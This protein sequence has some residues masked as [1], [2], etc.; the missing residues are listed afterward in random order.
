MAKKRIV[1]VDILRG[2]AAILMILGHSF[3]Q[4]PVNIEQIPWCFYLRHFIYTFHM[5]LF[6]VLAGVV[7]HCTDYK[8]FIQKKIKRILIPYAFFGVVTLL[9]KAFGGSAINGNETVKEGLIKFVFHGGNYWFLYVLF[10]V[11]AIYPFLEKLCQNRI[12]YEIAFGIGILIIREITNV[13]W[14]LNISGV[15]H[16][17]PFFILGRAV[18]KLFIAKQIKDDMSS[19][20][21]IIIVLSSC[22]LYLAIDSF[23]LI[24][25]T[26]VGM[27]LSF[28]RATCVMSILY[29]IVHSIC[30]KC[31]NGA[32]DRLVTDCG[33]YSLQLYLFNAFL[34]TALRIII[35]NMLHISSPFIIVGGIWIG[36]IAITLLACKKVIPHIPILRDLCGLT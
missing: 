20:M 19:R 35:C 2:I 7:Y 28:I 23:E 10:I 12:E 13:T 4:Y 16:Y 34:L 27:I 32:I 1:E 21:R 11:F 33:K 14:V 26:E 15:L 18:A 6:F 25:N 30:R 17:L 5:E 22:C 31:C 36:N 9:L 3:I 8:A 29:F 24:R